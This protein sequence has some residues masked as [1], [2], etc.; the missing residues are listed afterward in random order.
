MSKKTDI[1]VIKETDQILDETPDL[2]KSCKKIIKE[3]IANTGAKQAA[4]FSYNPLEKT[5]T[6]LAKTGTTDYKL[7]NLAIKDKKV[8][9][10]KSKGVATPIRIKNQILG[11]LYIGGIKN[12]N[13]AD[14]LIK[15]IEAILDGK[16]K[17]EFD[18]HNIKKTFSRYVGSAVMDK[19]LDRENEEMLSGENHHV[20]VMFVDINGFTSYANEHSPEH[21][22][23]LLN[24]FFENMGAVILKNKGT[25]DKFIGDEIMA[26]FGA[27]I[28]MRKHSTVAIKTANELIR[29][30][31]PLLKRHNIKKGGLSI[32]IASGRVISGNIGFSEMTDYTVIG[33]KVNLASR[34]T[35]LAEQNEILVDDTTKESADG[36]KYKSLGSQNIK[37]FTKMPV[38][39]VERK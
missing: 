4:I 31:K 1:Q 7:V 13:E 35:S 32:G 15:N 18:S 25:V 23:A 37:G 5:K 28:P 21:V 8:V 6:L 39:R 24:D 17:H 26:V 10:S 16:F 30:A 27:P 29:L 36:F 9:K 34:L 19:I 12:D 22:I 11:I 38:Y 20:S 2:I 3:V 14:K 33:R